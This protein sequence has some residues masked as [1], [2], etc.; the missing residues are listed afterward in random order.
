MT[1]FFLSAA[2]EKAEGGA[3][4]DLKDGM[5]MPVGT[6]QEKAAK[7]GKVRGLYQELGVGRDAQQTIL[8]LNAKALEA[9]SKVCDKARFEVLYY[10][11]EKLIGRTR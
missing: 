9:A 7:I 8:R 5:A 3:L 10:F 2:F 1:D 6:D 11:A 4:E